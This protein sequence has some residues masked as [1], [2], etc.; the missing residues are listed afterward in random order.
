MSVWEGCYCMKLDGVSLKHEHSSLLRHKALR[1]YS[2]PP[3]DANKQ[4]WV[5]SPSSTHTHGYTPTVNTHTHRHNSKKCRHPHTHA[6]IYTPPICFVYSQT[7]TSARPLHSFQ[8]VVLVI[9]SVVMSS[10]GANRLQVSGTATCEAKKWLVLVNH[11]LFLFF[12]GFI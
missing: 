2:P 11:R 7:H 5:N 12:S 3:P 8:F 1:D 9:Q 10:T 4:I 6:H